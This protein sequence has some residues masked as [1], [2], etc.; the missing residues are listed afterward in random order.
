[1]YTFIRSET[2]C[3]SRKCVWKSAASEWVDREREMHYILITCGGGG[4]KCCI[5]INHVSGDLPAIS[6]IFPLLLRIDKCM[7][8]SAISSKN[9]LLMGHFESLQR[10]EGKW[11]RSIF[12]AL[13]LILSPR[14]TA[15]EWNLFH[16]IC[17]C[18]P[19]NVKFYPPRRWI[20]ILRNR[21]IYK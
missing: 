14:R 15:A 5:Y 2:R 19:L 12:P 20:I 21:C 7:W 1:M 3:C 4:E 8:A 11:L 13:F 18:C 6:I 16:V 17:C 9:D 10:G